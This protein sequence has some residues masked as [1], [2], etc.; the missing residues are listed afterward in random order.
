MFL[1]IS[2]RPGTINWERIVFLP[3]KNLYRKCE[4]YAVLRFTIKSNLVAAA[5]KFLN[6]CY[7]YA[8]YYNYEIVVNFFHISHITWHDIQQLSINLPEFTQFVQLVNWQN[9]SCKFVQR[10]AQSISKIITCMLLRLVWG[11]DHGLPSSP[12]RWGLAL[13][14]L[15]R[16]FLIP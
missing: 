1:W 5:S 11:E 13:E 2:Q 15:Q 9:N 8:G 12:Y 7:I 6:S 3:S 4:C 16:S 10:I 14:A